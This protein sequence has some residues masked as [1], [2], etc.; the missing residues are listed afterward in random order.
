[1]F[2]DE[3]R[4][5]LAG[6][7]LPHKIR[8]QVR[9]MQVIG[10]R[11]ADKANPQTPV[12]EAISQF[13]V[14]ESGVREILVEWLLDE[15]FPCERDVRGIKKLVRTIGGIDDRSKTKLWTALGRDITHKGRY[16]ELGMPINVT[17]NGD[18]T[19]PAVRAQMTRQKPG[20]GDDIV[21][22]KQDNL[23]LSM[24]DTDVSGGGRAPVLHRITADVRRPGARLPYGSR[25]IIVRTIVH[26]D[27]VV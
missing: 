9:R 27:Y 19:F 8:F 14:L 10:K 26:N 22:D 17:Q 18:I 23:P 2:A 7:I 12:R 21:T 4:S 1:M 16:P 25:G 15:P 20:G 3:N 11:L 6:E 5:A 24:C 13:G